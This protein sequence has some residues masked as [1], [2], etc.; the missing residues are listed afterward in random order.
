MVQVYNSRPFISDSHFHPASLICVSH[1]D[2]PLTWPRRCSARM[3]AP[4][5]CT[6]RPLARCRRLMAHPMMART[7]RDAHV[8]VWASTQRTRLRRHLVREK[9]LTRRLVEATAQDEA[10]SAKL[11]PPKR[12]ATASYTVW[13]PAGRNKPAAQ[14]D[15]STMQE[16]HE[17]TRTPELYL[18]SHSA[19]AKLLF[20]TFAS[21]VRAGRKSLRRKEL[22]KPQMLCMHRWR[23]F[24]RTIVLRS[25]TDEAPTPS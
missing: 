22:A 9:L 18:A 8:F 1:V 2:G 15:P 14:N 23:A 19:G 12:R 11:S 20:K 13:A 21:S 4:S 6:P 5:M 17:L 7:R 10:R 24:L 25:Y 3:P 16:W